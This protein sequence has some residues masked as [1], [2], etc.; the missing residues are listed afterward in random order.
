MRM[1]TVHNRN[2]VATLPLFPCTFMLGCILPHMKKK[3]GESPASCVLFDS[4]VRSRIRG[5]GA[6]SHTRVIRVTWTLGVLGSMSE[7]EKGQSIQNWEKVVRCEKLIWEYNLENKPVICTVSWNKSLLAFLKQTLILLNCD[8][9]QTLTISTVIGLFFLL[10]SI[11]PLNVC[12]DKC[13]RLQHG[14]TKSNQ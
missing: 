6:E 2:Y 7:R 4:P 12:L 3:I 5:A 1:I 9:H 11:W 14:P 8:Q 10:P 13:W